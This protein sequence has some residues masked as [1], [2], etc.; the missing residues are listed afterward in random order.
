M[1]RLVRHLAWLLVI[2]LAVGACVRQV[3]LLPPDGGGDGTD[4]GGTSDGP[5]DAGIGDAGGID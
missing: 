3:V 4:G 2:A 1:R 5:G